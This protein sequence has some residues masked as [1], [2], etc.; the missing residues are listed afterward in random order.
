MPVSFM[1]INTHTIQAHK[2]LNIGNAADIVLIEAD[3]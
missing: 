2:A 1:T 3:T